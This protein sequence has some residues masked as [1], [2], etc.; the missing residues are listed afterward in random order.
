MSDVRSLRPWA[1]GVVPALTGAEAAAWDRRAI[2]RIGVPERVLMENA[3]RAAALVLH[4]LHPDGPVVGV[5]GA[6]NNGGDA[7]VALRTLAAWGRDVRA[8]LVADR[9]VPHPLAH[10]WDVPTSTDA[11][12]DAPG[13][14]ALLEGA[15][16]VV[17]GILGTGVRGAPRERQA[18][19]I[20]AVNASARAV[21]AV[22]VPSGIDPETG[23]VPGEAVRADVTV[24]FGAPKLGSLLHPARALVGRL[25]AV[26]IGFP[27]LEE[28]EARAFLATPGWARAR[29]PR[30]A[31]DTHKNAVGRLLVVG[32]GMGLAGAAVLAGRGALRAGVGIVRVATVPGNREIVQSA[33]PEALWVDATDGSAVRAAV[34][35]SDAVVVGPGLGQDDDARRVLAWVL[36]GTEGVEGVG[37]TDR[38]I[39]LDA[40]A[41]NLAA[42]GVVDLPEVGARRPTLLTPHPGE[43]GRLLGDGAVPGAENTGSRGP[44]ARAR[45]A[46]ERFHA[47]VVLKGAPSLVAAEDGPL[48]VDTQGSSD[49]AAAG[50]GDTLSGVCGA[51]LAQGLS[52]ADAGAV[53][54]YLTGRAARLAGKGVSLTPSDVAERL[55]DVLAEAV[56]PTASAQTDAGP[57]GLPFVIFDADPAD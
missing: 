55:P 25:V 15:A 10:G 36:D 24:A 16:V 4:R 42:S 21:L 45:A 56:D 14:R 50:M 44:A 5:V 54:L 23:A 1:R 18:A 34:E 30:R 53:G 20:R 11:E 31:T 29:L 19:A 47:A 9:E 8:V 17:D 39:L 43:I 12:L 46:A 37:E 35:G 49:L 41:L 51:L 57:L 27:P 38:P 48:R 26:E 32:G 33:L 2:D 22:D 28:G 13:W 52:P 6:G 40:D 7:L 3:G